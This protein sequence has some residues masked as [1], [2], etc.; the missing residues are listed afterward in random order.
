MQGQSDRRCLVEGVPVRRLAPATAAVGLALL[1]VVAGPAA[2]GSA[3]MLTRTGSP[4]PSPA[5]SVTAASPMP[6]M[7][8]SGTDASMPGMDMGGAVP[9]AASVPATSPSVPSPTA[10]APPSMPGMVMDGGSM[11]G[12]TSSHDSEVAPVARPR[13][14]VLGTFVA[15][16]AAVMIAAVILRHRTRGDRDRRATVQ[17]AARVP[18]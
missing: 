6:G 8:M 16:N 12:M 15:V 5:A 1:I 10:V 4:H 3:S 11:P 18:A 13:A 14:Q 7:D 2:T 9:G 17:R